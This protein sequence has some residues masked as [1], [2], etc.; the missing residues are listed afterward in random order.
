MLFVQYYTVYY[1]VLKQNGGS[2][3]DAAEAA[4]RVLEDNKDF[5]AGRGSLLN[6]DGEVE[7]DAMIMEGHTLNNGSIIYLQFT[8]S[9]YLCPPTSHAPLR[10]NIYIECILVHESCL[11]FLPCVNL[12]ICHIDLTMSEITKHK[13][14]AKTKGRFPLTKISIG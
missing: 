10:N 5:N 1:N 6:R 3:V 11:H 9:L 4:V 7:C 8:Y 14:S 2:A 13:Q 12:Q